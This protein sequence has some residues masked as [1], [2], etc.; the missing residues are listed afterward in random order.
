ME[1]SFIPDRNLFS[2]THAALKALEKLGS[3]TKA[4]NISHPSTQS[5]SALDIIAFLTY[6]NTTSWDEG[7]YF[8]NVVLKHWSNSLGIWYKYFYEDFILAE[9]DPTTP[10][11]LDFR[12]RMI[13]LLPILF[14]FSNSN[15]EE[16]TRRICTLLRN[17]G[18]SLISLTAK[19]WL[20]L[21]E[22]D[23]P[24]TFKWTA[25][26]LVIFHSGDT[27]LADEL[28]ENIQH[29]TDRDVAGLAIREMSQFALMCRLSLVEVETL[30][31]FDMF[32]I[33]ISPCFYRG[34]PLHIPF[35]TRGGITA[36]VKVLSGLLSRPT[37]AYYESGTRGSVT[38]LTIARICFSLLKRCLDHPS[39]A[40]EA[41]EAG[42]LKVVVKAAKHYGDGKAMEMDHWERNFGDMVSEVLERVSRLLVYPSVF[43]R[44]KRSIAKYITTEWE[45]SLQTGHERLRHVWDSCLD[46]V[47][48]LGYVREIM[49]DPEWAMCD[50]NECP[51]QDETNDRKSV[52]KYV[53]CSSCR[54]VVYC[55]RACAKKNWPQHKAECLTATRL[56][57]EGKGKP[58][59]IDNAVFVEVIHD[60]V[61]NF[62]EDI[63]EQL[64]HF[65]TEMSSKDEVHPILVLEFD[66]PDPEWNIGNRLIEASC[67]DIVDRD[68]VL[69]DERLLP[70]SKRRILDYTSN[71]EL[72]DPLEIVAVTFFP[73]PL[74]LDAWQVVMAVSTQETELGSDSDGV[75]TEM[76]TK[77]G[78]VEDS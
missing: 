12:D 50:Y 55:S 54:T 39:S 68:L 38:G 6:H 23:H 36:L 8:K 64:E 48:C 74:A 18:R 37:L 35:L 51:N 7:G 13:W 33:I 65:K 49:K 73:A 29:R 15:P 22:T 5:R 34:T 9:E 3:P 44:F 47:D 60:Y 46:N 11:G 30:S 58:D 77:A 59:P 45:E 26:V 32:M 28:E 24:A 72:L 41:L 67:F 76:E 19:A 71:I 40:S 57:K 56:R 42:L 52:A 10:T 14:L 25:F 75:S 4:P 43:L 69:R 16:R 78:S 20:K 61:F 17:Q 62:R 70:S 53:R 1:G 31:E 27:K 2:S 63:V 21:I 66:D